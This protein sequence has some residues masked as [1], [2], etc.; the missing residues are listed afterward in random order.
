MIVVVTDG[1][2]DSE[3]P[4]NVVSYPLRKQK[5]MVNNKEVDAI[6]IM[7]VS[8]GVNRNLA[9]LN[10]IVTPPINENVFVAANYE[11]MYNAVRQLAKDSC[12]Y[13]SCKYFGYCLHLL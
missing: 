6:R 12:E 2:S 7:A 9:N 11:D 10:Q 5:T 8:V 3:R 13:K 1:N 4:L